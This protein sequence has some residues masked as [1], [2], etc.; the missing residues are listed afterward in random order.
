MQKIGETETGY[1][2]MAIPP[3]MQSPMMDHEGG[4]IAVDDENRTMYCW[5]IF[6]ALYGTESILNACN[7][8][9]P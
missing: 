8:Y 7:Q 3:G 9:Q 4:G 2:V 6:V 5:G 1:T